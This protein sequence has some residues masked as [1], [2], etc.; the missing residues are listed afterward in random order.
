MIFNE[1]FTTSGCSSNKD[2]PVLH[3]LFHIWHAHSVWRSKYHFNENGKVENNINENEVID[4]QV[5]ILDEIVLQKR[6][7]LTEKEK[8]AYITR[9]AMELDADSCA[10]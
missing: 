4:A 7:E 8:Q 3:E 5:T 2:V 10:I 6:L 9:Q 1:S